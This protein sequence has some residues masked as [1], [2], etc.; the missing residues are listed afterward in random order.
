MALCCCGA[1]LQAAPTPQEQPPATATSEALDV[2]T[3]SC[4]RSGDLIKL[5]ALLD[6]QPDQL[7]ALDLSSGG[8]PAHWAA[9]HD[10]LEVLKMLHQRGARLNRSTATTQMQPIHWASTRENIAVVE[11]LINTGGCAADA[12]DVRGTTPLMMAAQHDRAHLIYWFGK[13][14]PHTLDI[15]DE[16]ADSAFHWAAYKDSLTSLMML[17]GYGMRPGPQVAH[18]HLQPAHAPA[19]CT[20]VPSFRITSGVHLCACACDAHM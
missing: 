11:W 6:L 8:S 9:L 12:T 7:E 17:H 18:M 14:W 3:I 15:V 19:T 1:A 16:D 4:I 5:T 10:Q 20:C 2:E 13:H